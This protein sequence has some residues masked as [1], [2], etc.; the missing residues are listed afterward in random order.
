MGAYAGRR[1]RAIAGA[2]VSWSRSARTAR[3]SYSAVDT[4]VVSAA[5]RMT[6]TPSCDAGGRSAGESAGRA[7]EVETRADD[8][9]RLRI[10]QAGVSIAALSSFADKARFHT[11]TSSISPLNHSPHTAL[12][13]IFSGMFD[14]V[15]GPLAARCALRTPLT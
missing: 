1:V 5:A 10:S 7:P 3:S 2:G 12:P 6:L 4:P 8:G 9:F 13:P 14:A 11:R 15:I